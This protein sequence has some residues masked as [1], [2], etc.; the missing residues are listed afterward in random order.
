L[1]TVIPASG[2]IVTGKDSLAELSCLLAITVKIARQSSHASIIADE[3][4]L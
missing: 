3:L 1:K 2:P 4:M